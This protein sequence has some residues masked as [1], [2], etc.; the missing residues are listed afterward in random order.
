MKKIKAQSILLLFL[1]GVLGAGTTTEA[2]IGTVDNV[3]ASTLLL[4]YFEVDL[5]AGAG[6]TTLFSINNSSASATM[7]HVT[8]WTDLGVPTANFDVYLTG[9]DVQTINVRDILNGT[10]PQTA[11]AGQDPTDTISPQGN[12]S[13][14]INFASCNGTGGILPPPSL[15]A[16]VAAELR[17][18]HTGQAAATLFGGN[19]GG[20]NVGDNLARGYITIDV[21]NACTALT[22]SDPGYFVN[23]GG[24]I[25]G[26]RNIL[27]GDYFYVN[28]AQNFA[29]GD[30]LVHIE[31]SSTNPQTSVSGQYTFYGRYVGWTAVDNREPLAT[32]FAARFISGGAFSGGTSL[33]A[34]RDSKVDQASFVC[35]AP[36]AGLAQEDVIAFDEAENAENVMTVS[37]SPFPASAQRVQVDGAALP[38]TP[39]FGWLYMNL[40]HSGAANP[41]EDNA[42]A[43]A[44]VSNVMDANGRFSVG[45]SAIV[46]QKATATAHNCL[47][48]DPAPC[49]P[50]AP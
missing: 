23:G 13:Q 5:G 22:P 18:A 8:L 42:A 46:L 25:A 36:P 16:T 50:F 33:V 26:N 2:A 9:F 3:P 10:L 44:W 45:Q 4:P 38:V 32:T 29:Q 34:W 21:T 15:T 11:S 17:A 35:A 20:R 47:D 48:G 7:A 27:Y 28:A 1:A 12:F 37:A 31:T 19:C 39:A 49:F 41:P 14:D 40:N 43:Q 24:G 6:V 30:A